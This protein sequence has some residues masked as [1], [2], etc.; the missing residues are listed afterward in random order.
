[1]NANEFYLYAAGGTLLAAIGL[2]LFCLYKWD[3]TASVRKLILCLVGFVGSAALAGYVAP[4]LYYEGAAYAVHPDWWILR[5]L[6]GGVITYRNLALA[7]IGVFL[8]FYAW[9]SNSKDHH[10]DVTGRIIYASGTGRESKHL[11]FGLLFAIPFLWIGGKGLYMQFSANPYLADLATAAQNDQQIKVSWDPYFGIDLPADK[12]FD[13]DVDALKQV[14]KDQKAITVNKLEKA[15]FYARDNHR[16][17]GVIIYF[18]GKHERLVQSHDRAA[19]AK[20]AQKYEE[21]FSTPQFGSG[22]SA[23]KKK[24]TSILGD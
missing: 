11:L 23:P 7:G 20:W 16:I 3:N 24:T 5:D 18:D 2:F 8:L 15:V 14:A 4:Y 6:I 19:T 10:T 1:M 22:S 12:L 9:F 21:K 13:S 17:S